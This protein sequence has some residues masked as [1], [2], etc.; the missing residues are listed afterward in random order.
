MLTVPLHFILCTSH[1]TAY[2]LHLTPRN[3]TSRLTMDPLPCLSALVLVILTLDL[4]LLLP[5]PLLFMIAYS[6]QLT[7]PLQQEI[8]HIAD[9]FDSRRDWQRLFPGGHVFDHCWLLELRYR[10][11]RRG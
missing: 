11:C 5:L 10:C 2:S 8:A 4:L 1:P 7:L 3:P 9:R 6:L